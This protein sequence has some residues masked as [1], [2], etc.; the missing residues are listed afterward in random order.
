[1]SSEIKKKDYFLMTV[2]CALLAGSF[3]YVATMNITETVIG[4]CLVLG[5][6][7]ALMAFYSLFK[8]IV[9]DDMV[10]A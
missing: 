1:M 10:G 5:G 8:G 2:I 4:L 3:F 7:C 6:Y 9:T